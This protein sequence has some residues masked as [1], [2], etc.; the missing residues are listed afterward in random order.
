VERE[1][2]VNRNKVLESSEISIKSLQSRCREEEV[3]MRNFWVCNLWILFSIYT[4]GSYLSHQETNAQ[5]SNL[6]ALH[7]PVS[8]CMQGQLHHHTEVILRRTCLSL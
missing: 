5:T 8:A 3:K 6:G 2:Q 1:H 4:S 7:D